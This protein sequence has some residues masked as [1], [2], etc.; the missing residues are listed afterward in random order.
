MPTKKSSKCG[1]DCECEEMKAKFK[2]KGDELLT[3]VKEAI[4]E[5]NVRRII[6]KDNKG[7]PYIEIPVTV[8]VVGFVIAPILVAVG[9]LAAMVE[10]FDVE[11][12]RREG[13][14]TKSRTTR[15]PVKKSKKK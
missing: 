11:L 7:K 12:I 15:K 5:G 6:I 1:C 9:A 14:P 2:V 8:G 10:V 13:K 3:F 4:H